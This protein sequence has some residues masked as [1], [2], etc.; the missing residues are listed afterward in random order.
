MR[1]TVRGSCTDLFL[2]LRPVWPT[3]GQE[4]VGQAGCCFRPCCSERVWARNW[5]SI[6][7]HCCCCGVSSA[8]ALQASLLSSA[9]FIIFPHRD[10]V[11]VIKAKIIFAA[12]TE[13]NRPPCEPAWLGEENISKQ[14][15]FIKEHASLSRPPPLP[16][17][18]TLPPTPLRPPPL[19]SVSL[20]INR[21]GS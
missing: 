8:C 12:K 14:K 20:R 6:D 11:L 9:D 13:C 18:P 19:S 2:K 4:M 21:Q 15:Q 1:Q 3:V 7:F 16:P 5:S 10:F 17:P